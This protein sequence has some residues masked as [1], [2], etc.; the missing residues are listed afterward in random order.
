[1]EISRRKL[2]SMSVGLVAAGVCYGITRSGA[3][4]ARQHQ[5]GNGGH[6]NGMH[7]QGMMHHTAP[8]A[9]RFSLPTGQE[10]AQLP[11]LRNESSQPGKF[12]ASLTAS[13][14]AVNLIPNHQPTILWLYNKTL[15]P[16][17]E[18]QVGDDVTI[19]FNNQ[20]SQD[21]TIHWHGL[22]VPADQDGN[23]QDPIAPNQS[24][25]YQFRITEEMIGTHWFH[26]HTHGHVAEQ[27]YHGL[28][29]VFIV[30]DPND[31][32]KMIPEKNLFFSDLK[33]DDTGQIAPNS[34]M[35]VMNG[36][37]G[38]FTLLNGQLKPNITINGT[39]RWRIWNGNS[40]RYLDFVFP[41]DQV[42]AYLVGNDS[43]LL[44]APYKIEQLLMT[45]G[46]RAEIVLTPKNSGQFELIAK[47]YDRHKMGMVPVETDRVLATVKLMKGKKINLPKTLR[48]IPDYGEPTEKRQIVFSEGNHMDFYVN[49]KQYDMGRI[50]ITTKIGQVEEWEI[51]N[52]SHM[53]HNFHLHGNHF[54]VK[55]FELNNQ[56]TK[57]PFKLQKDTIN[58]KP[59]EKVRILTVQKLSGIRMY[60]CHI[61]EHE[62]AGMMGQLLAV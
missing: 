53:D 51:F 38:Q 31:P 12:I 20:L 19:T 1:M 47:A 33:L 5:M 59:Y 62:N 21:G 52:N 42:D 22:P 29:G 40:A 49:G 36:R 57:P 15:L 2:L 32:L 50:D 37:E 60:H 10:L 24:H 46:E 61:L 8:A 55:E 54:L 56:I 44:E 39:S 58:L 25:Q 11:L 28:A 23:P 6:M 41:S 7:N 34:M 27:V 14:A 43:G 45:P 26:P 48:K 16:V 4:T 30:R 3:V 18:T 35:D 13:L 9:D 17:I